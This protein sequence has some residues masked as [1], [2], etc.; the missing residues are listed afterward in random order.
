MRLAVV[1]E[2]LLELLAGRENAALDSSERKTCVFGYFI[3]LV[4]GHVHRERY[5]VFFGELVDSL[6]YFLSAVALFGRL[7]AALLPEVEQVQVVGG[8]D[9]VAL[10][11]VRR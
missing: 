11:T 7:G 8:I 5:A 1:G 9:P 10:R 3:V 4:A 2:T 6:C